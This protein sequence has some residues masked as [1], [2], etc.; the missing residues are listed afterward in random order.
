MFA[1]SSA[2]RF[3]IP[4]MT[5]SLV[6][7]CLAGCTGTNLSSP[8][9]SLPTPQ[10]TQA[11]LGAES[12]PEPVPTNSGGVAAP[13]TVDDTTNVTGA[14]RN[15]IVAFRAPTVVLYNS[16]D[17]NDGQRVPAAA[18]SLPMSAKPANAKRLEVATAEGPKWIAMSDVRISQ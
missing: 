8:A 2:Q 10:N 9:L 17:G 11:E 5:W 1:K 18:F 4:I 7:V 14:A 12:A 15:T 6:A 13:S 16:I 3:H